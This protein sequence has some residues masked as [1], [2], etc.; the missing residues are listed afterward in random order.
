VRFKISSI[1]TCAF[2]G[3]CGTVAADMHDAQKHG[4]E[5][6]QQAAE[7]LS[8]NTKISYETALQRLKFQ[9]AVEKTQLTAKL[10]E[11][12][13]GHIAGIYLEHE[14]QS[15]VVVRLKGD[16]QIANRKLQFDENTL[17][18]V[19][20]VSGGKYTHDELRTALM[21][22]LYTLKSNLPGFDSAYAS[23]KTGEVVIHV[24]GEEE[25]SDY[26]KE[27]AQKILEVPVRI[28]VLSAFTKEQ[29]IRGGASVV[30]CTTGFTVN[31]GIGAIRGVITAAHCG[32][33]STVYYDGNGGSG[34]L[35]Y[36]GMAYSGNE[37]VLWYTPHFPYSYSAVKP[38]FYANENSPPAVLTGSVSSADVNVGS[39]F[40]HRGI[41][42]GY[43]CG[44]DY[45]QKLSVL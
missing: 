14:P 8:R 32:A 30:V 23:E 24:V 26:L 44:Q 27:V 25:K 35:Q 29:A 18:I 13:N 6:R 17:L 11:E 1:F 36:K 5:A 42:T 45:G 19:D 4:Q 16:M 40:C 43:S 21:K 2:M 12:F 38:E 31:K 3:I 15:R 7:F 20:F 33:G 9:D 41:T 39:F 34:I 22:N 10:R 28:S 37:D